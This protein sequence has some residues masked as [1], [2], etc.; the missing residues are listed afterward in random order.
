MRTPCKADKYG[1]FI[2]L[3]FYQGPS[4]KFFGNVEID[5]AKIAGGD[6]VPYS[7]LISAEMSYSMLAME[8][9]RCG[10]K[11]KYASQT[12]ADIEN[13]IELPAFINL[14][15]SA[16]K[17]IFENFSLYAEASNLLNRKNYCYHGYYEKTLDVTAG[18]IYVW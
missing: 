3:L 2:N 7:P 12:Y 16:E 1:A 11:V 4:G 13:K 14:S 17:N 10:V 18:I 15:I 5:H 9:I 8:G 6:V